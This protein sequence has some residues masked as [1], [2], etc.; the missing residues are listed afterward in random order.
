MPKKKKEETDSQSTNF[1]QVTGKRMEYDN[2]NEE[3]KTTQ[4]KEEIPDLTGIEKEEIIDSSGFIYNQEKF[5]K[6]FIPE[7]DL[8]KTISLIT[9]KVL[10]SK[11]NMQI[12]ISKHLV[13][14]KFIS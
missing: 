9:L 10:L 1:K 7:N 5:N 3:S 6:C 2:I 8:A 12:E 13:P 14:K 11:K 4:N